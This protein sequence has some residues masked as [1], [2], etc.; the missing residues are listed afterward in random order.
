MNKVDA[1][2]AERVSIPLISTNVVIPRRKVTMATR[3]SISQ[4]RR[5]VVFSGERLFPVMVTHL[6]ICIWRSCGK[7]TVDRLLSV[8]KKV[9]LVHSFPNIFG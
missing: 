4:R 7:R 5:E 2:I 6:L 9:N 8:S 3:D 1:D